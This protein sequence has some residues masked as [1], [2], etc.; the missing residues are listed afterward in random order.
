[1]AMVK[2]ALAG[3]NCVFHTICK[4]SENGIINRNL[5]FIV[6]QCNLSP[7]SYSSTRPV[8]G[9][10]DDHVSRSYM[11]KELTDVPEG[12]SSIEGFTN[13]EIKDFINYIATF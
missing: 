9:N 12:T 13:A 1:M 7:D 3:K 11:I 6:H 10:A 5:R 2:G 8:T 4:M